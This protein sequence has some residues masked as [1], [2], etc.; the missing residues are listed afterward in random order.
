MNSNAGKKKA[1]TGKRTK[2]GIEL[3]ESAKEILAH[4]KGA[5]KLPVW[6]IVLPDDVDVKQIRMQ[7]GDVARR[8]RERILYQ[9]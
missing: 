8:I 4:L 3:E 1:P 9:S 5:A 6:R 7:T 2:L